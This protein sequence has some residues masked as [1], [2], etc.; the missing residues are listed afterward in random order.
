MDLS[1]LPQY[2]VDNVRAATPASKLFTLGAIILWLMVFIWAK[3]HKRYYCAGLILATVFCF[4]SESLAI[5]LGKYHYGAFALS[6]PEIDLPFLTSKLQQLSG[7]GPFPTLITC[8]ENFSRHIPLEVAFLEAAIILAMF[9]VTNLLTQHAAIGTPLSVRDIKSIGP[10]FWLLMPSAVF[11]GALA[12]NLDAILDPVVSGTLSCDPTAPGEHFNGLAL[13]TWHTTGKYAG[14]WFGVPLANYTAWFAG[15]FAFTLAVRM[16]KKGIVIGPTQFPRAGNVLVVVGSF[17][18]LVF[19]LFV[20]K[21]SLDYVLYE[22][23]AVFAAEHLMSA[24][25]WQF[26]VVGTLITVGFAFGLMEIKKFGTAS[27]FELAAIAPPVFVFLYC[28][29]GLVAAGLARPYGRW[30]VLIWS[31]TALIASG[32]TAAP[33]VKRQLRQSRAASAPSEV[34]SGV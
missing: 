20:V 5:R 4:V 30:L 24:K 32:H 3:R 15:V 13:W 28:L 8:Q 29:G 33:F 12:L 9:R 31:G 1:L 18:F 27:R 6:I 26:L 21:F 11:N 22:S 16:T 2:F 10:W 14:Y 23:P 19:L 17:L 7:K 34:P 25:W